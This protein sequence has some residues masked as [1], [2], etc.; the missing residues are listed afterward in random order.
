MERDEKTDSPVEVSQKNKQPGANKL[1]DSKDPLLE[2][3]P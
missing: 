2:S 3:Q 1:D